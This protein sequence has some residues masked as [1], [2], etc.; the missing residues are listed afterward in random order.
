MCVFVYMCTALSLL[1]SINDTSEPPI[2]EKAIRKVFDSY[3]S[4]NEETMK[5]A[6]DALIARIETENVGAVDHSDSSGLPSLTPLILRLNK[7]Y[8]NDSGIFAPILLNFISL[9]PYESFFMGAG[10][11][12]AYISG[13]CIECMALSD[14]VMRVGLTPKYKDVATLCEMLEYR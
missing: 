14:N 1:G 6:I 2:Q 3:M 12:H 13:D 7:Q 8:P 5:S 11:P 9:S 10:V 4:C